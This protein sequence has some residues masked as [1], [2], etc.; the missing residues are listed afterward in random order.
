MVLVLRWRHEGLRVE[1][2]AMTG[3]AGDLLG[4]L[5]VVFL[6]LHLRGVV[7]VDLHGHFEHET[8]SLFLRLGVVGKVQRRAAVGHLPGGIDRV[9]GVAFNPELA[10][11]FVHDVVH[12]VSG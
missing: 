9:A 6:A 4:G 11:P 1:M 3:S 7:L 2:P 8:S 5:S 12:L 10:L